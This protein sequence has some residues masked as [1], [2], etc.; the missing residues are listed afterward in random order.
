MDPRSSRT[1]LVVAGLLAA[2]VLG[3]GLGAVAFALVDSDTET[4]VRRVTV[5]DSQPVS[6]GAL[7][8]SQIYDS[9]SKAVVIPLRPDAVQAAP[10]PIPLGLD[11][12]A[13]SEGGPFD[14]IIVL[15]VPAGATLSPGTYD[16]MID[17]WVLRP[18]Q[19]AELSVLPAKGHNQDFT[20][21]LF[22]VCLQ[23]GSRAAPR[24]VAQV[25][26]SVG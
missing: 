7:A 18:R 12:Q 23:S 22:G 8:V 11:P 16:P 13:L 6:S 20:L 25:P 2:L 14:A 10:A 15:G 24:L 21:S 1:P 3:V 4:V 19:L 9:A 26:V 5:G 17:A